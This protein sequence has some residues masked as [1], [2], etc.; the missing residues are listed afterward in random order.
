MVDIKDKHGR[1]EEED[2]IG[3][4]ESN[5]QPKLVI[6]QYIIVDII[7][8]LYI[9]KNDVIKQKDQELYFDYIDLTDK[10]LI[11]EKI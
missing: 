8:E 4:F 9:H 2:M 3:H 11:I 1:C 10:T 6:I 7:E 5:L